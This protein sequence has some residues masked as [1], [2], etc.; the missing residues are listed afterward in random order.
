MKKL[1]FLLCFFSAFAND[2]GDD[3]SGESVRIREGNFALRSSQMPAPL[4]SLGQLI[5]DKGDQQMYFFVGQLK[6]KCF[7]YI[8]FI[9]FLLYGLRDDLSLLVAAP[10]AVKFQENGQRNAGFEDIYATLEYAF[11]ANAHPTYATQMTILGSIYCPTGTRTNFP[12]TGL[13]S[14]SFFFGPTANYMSLEW[15]LFASV[16]GQF[17]VRNRYNFRPG[18]AFYYN[19][20]IGRNIAYKTNTYI[21]NCLLELNGIYQQ[22]DTQCRSKNPNSGGHI[23]SISPSLWFSTR[24]L[25]L[26]LGISLPIHQKLNGTQNKETYLLAASMAWTFN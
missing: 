5:V 22:H 21:F 4:F 9:P 10:T 11:L 26:Q 23:L 20:G 15:Y 17:A 2:D 16:F 13:G 18:N 3:K 14:T 8:D 6:G 12:P 24:K 1:F 19:A 25:I 7:N